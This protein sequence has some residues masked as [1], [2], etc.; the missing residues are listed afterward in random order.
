MM[1]EQS[2]SEA[3]FYYFKLEDHVPQTHLLRLIDR[4]VDF[5]FLRQR[6]RPLYSETGR[7]SVDPEVLLR[8]LLIGYAISARSWLSA[9]MRSLLAWRAR[10]LTSR[11]PE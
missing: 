7:P 1:G 11:L 2:K 8:I 4:Y 6:L 9:S 5:G 3:L 10:R